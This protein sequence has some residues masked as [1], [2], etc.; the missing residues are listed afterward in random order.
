MAVEF[1]ELLGDHHVHSTFSDDAVSTVGENIAAAQQRGLS[2]IRL[3]DHVRASSTW[4]SDYLAAVRAEDSLGVNVLTGVETKLLDSSGRL[5]LPAKLP[6]L[7]AILIADH[8]FPGTDGPWT[9]AATVEKGLA[10]EDALDLLI[11]A[12]VNAMGRID[13]GQLAHPFSILPK[14]G[15]SEDDLSDE[16]LRQW[17]ISA[18]S[19][20]TLIEVNEKWGC[21]GPRV[22]R[23]AIAAGATLVASTDSHRAAD[24]GRYDTVTELLRG[25]RHT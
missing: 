25:S 15:L 9:P 3:V 19:T 14:I 1:A 6:R 17:A 5:D 2:T 21:P 8:Q 7:D 20:G 4:V 23:A 18:S 22:L 11:S 16:H 10:P 24:V 12:Y 13:N